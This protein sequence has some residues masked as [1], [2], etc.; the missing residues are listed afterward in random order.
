[1]FYAFNPK[2]LKIRRADKVSK[3]GKSKSAKIFNTDEEFHA[4]LSEFMER[5]EEEAQQH[6]RALNEISS[7]I[8]KIRIQLKA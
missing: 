5:Q 7:K 6:I 8:E 3:L 1:M 2:T 4:F